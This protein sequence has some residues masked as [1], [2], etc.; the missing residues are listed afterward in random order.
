MPFHNPIPDPKEP[1]KLAGAFKGYI[2]SEKL[3]QTA[4]VPFAALLIGWAAGY[5]ADQLFHTKWI[6]IAGMFLGCVSGVYYVIQMAFLA[7]KKSERDDADSPGKGSSG[8]PQ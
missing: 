4:M 3:M 7:E 8:T 6:F 2:E 5:G 1:S